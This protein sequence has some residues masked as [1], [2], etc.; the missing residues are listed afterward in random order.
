MLRNMT[1][2]KAAFVLA[3]VLTCVVASASWQAGW[4]MGNGFWASITAAVGFACVT[5]AFVLTP[6]FAEDHFRKGEW[7]STGGMVAFCAMLML[8]EVTAAA[9]FLVGNSTEST[10][11][12]MIQD[13]K[14]D[15]TRKSLNDRAVQLAAW[16][17]DI[18]EI[19]KTKPEAVSQNVDDAQA[20]IASAQ[21]VIDK[22]EKNGGC[23]KRCIEATV[24]KGK[25]LD[26]IATARM[27]VELNKKADA[28]AKE[29]EAARMQASTVKHGDAR[30]V[31]ASTMIAKLVSANLKPGEDTQ[32]W[33]RI[34]QELLRAMVF[35]IA[36]AVLMMI[37]LRKPHAAGPAH[38]VDMP[39]TPNARPAQTAAAPTMTSTPMRMSVM[40]SM[41][42]LA[43][44]S[45]KTMAQGAAAG[46][47][48][49]FVQQRAA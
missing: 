14:L 38:R 16:R 10:N 44:T 48:P 17:T 5:V 32:E 19:K 9:M 21:A 26:R 18:D 42:G 11:A 49:A 12:A 35:S 28:E 22:E 25:L 40:P 3:C 2:T 34:G 41:P 8:A 15:D 20:Q 31:A 47:F 29:L 13:T 23:K 43:F 37:G 7:A 6:H 36:A 45:A 46:A 39:S 24:A 33:A 4:S 27:Y 1:S 30:V